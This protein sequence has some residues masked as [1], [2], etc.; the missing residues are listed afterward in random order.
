MTEDTDFNI[1]STTG[2]G[3]ATYPIE[4]SMLRNN[5]HVVLSGRPCKVVDLAQ[6]GNNVRIAGVDIF[7]SKHYEATVSA[8]ATVDVPNVTRTD[9]TLIDI[10]KDVLS[11]LAEDG[12]IRDDFR[13]PDSELGKALMAATRQGK[14]SSCRCSRRWTKAG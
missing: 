6:N 2:A 9:Y 11:L 10:N 1:E 14:M 8:D 13:L 4:A 12:T 7:T 3:S 5:G